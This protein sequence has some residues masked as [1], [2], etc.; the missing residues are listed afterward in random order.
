MLAFG[1]DGATAGPAPFKHENRK[2][3]CR[4]STHKLETSMLQELLYANV[5]CSEK[6]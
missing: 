6:N 2:W 5:M 4:A 1:K 3:A